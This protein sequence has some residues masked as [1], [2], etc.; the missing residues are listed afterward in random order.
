MFA[1]SRSAPA[2]SWK[3]FVCLSLSTGWAFQNL[4]L[5]NKRENRIRRVKFSMKI[6]HK[7]SVLRIRKKCRNQYISQVD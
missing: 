6:D 3:V 5:L 1:C 2:K 7:V 4:A